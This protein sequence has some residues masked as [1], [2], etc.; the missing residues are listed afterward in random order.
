M[1]QERFGKHISLI[2]RYSQIFMDQNLSNY[3][4]GSGQYVFLLNLLQNKGVNQEKLSNILMINKATTARA[5]KKL[6]KEGYVVRNTSN[7][8][9]RSYEL[10]PTEKAEAI[11]AVLMKLLD[12]W[13][14]I[15]LKDF[16]DE[17][18]DQ[19]FILIEKVGNNLFNN[20]EHFGNHD[21]DMDL[22]N[23]D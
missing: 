8:D 19:L 21:E 10:Y 14:G 5:I 4:L 16:S 1:S 23:I 13:N 20:L 22:E 12:T 3:N 15:L 2:Y 17:E 6:E 7:E 9:K 11:E 18:K